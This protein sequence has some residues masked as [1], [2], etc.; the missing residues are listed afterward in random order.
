L[1]W[2]LDPAGCTVHRLGPAPEKKV[3][4]SKS[5]ATKT[6]LGLPEV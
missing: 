1:Q 5:Q 3:F 2:L 6:R 4:G